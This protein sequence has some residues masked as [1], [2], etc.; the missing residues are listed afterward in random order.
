MRN[1]LAEIGG[2][3]VDTEGDAFQ[4]MFPNVV[5]SLLFCFKVQEDLL[6]Y[7]WPQSV[8]NLYGCEKVESKLYRNKHI[9]SGPGVQILV[10]ENA[11]RQLAANGDEGAAGYPIFEDL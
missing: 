8:L 10:T 3:E 1:A 6:E 9:W 4:C 5:T 2:L 7:D 11:W